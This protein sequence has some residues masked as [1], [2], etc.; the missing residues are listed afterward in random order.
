MIIIEYLASFIE[1]MIAADFVINY[2]GTKKNHNKLLI[3]FIITVIL[4][5]SINILNHAMIFEGIYSLLYVVILTICNLIFLNGRIIEKIFSA[6]LS[7]VLVAIINMTLLTIFSSILSVTVSELITERNIFR[8]IILFFTKFL[9][10]IMSRFILV[11]RH[12]LK[13]YLNMI[14]WIMIALI[15]TTTLAIS[16][17]VLNYEY[18]FNLS[19]T[20][21][22]LLLVVVIGIII[23]N[24]V[25][26]YLFTVLSKHYQEMLKL[27]GIK[28]QIEQQSKSLD[29]L[30][31]LSLEMRKIQHDTAKYIDITSNL[32]SEAKYSKA[33][34]YLSNIRK[35]KLDNN[36]HIITTSND[37][38]NAIL[39]TKF[40]YCRKNNIDF[41]YQ[42]TADLSVFSDIELSVLLGNLLDNAIEGTISCTNP[43]VKI[44]ISENK[45]Y[46]IIIV[47]N[48]ISSSV[49]KNNSDFN[50]TKK[51]KIHHGLGL[52]A[53][54]DIVEKHDGMLNFTEEDMSFSAD[55]RLKRPD[56]NHK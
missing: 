11:M 1:S 7:I 15:F 19:S 5:I 23:I 8:L 55:I 13:S 16:L 14:E 20:D 54:N 46:L 32:I 22:N 56:I 3:F 6:I 40:S 17:L 53:I 28:I 45:A 27:S 47:T 9:Y 2:N 4:F 48:A 24:L 41:I 26:F 18:K 34:E 36:F 39:N 50:T 21:Y 33:L 30:K 49:L 12:K 51:D 31:S 29:D 43:F 44:S 25:T 35:N 10:Y 37:I 52:L 42:I 38:V